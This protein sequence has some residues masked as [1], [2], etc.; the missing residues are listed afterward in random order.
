MARD[1]QVALDVGGFE[2]YEL[3]R[4]RFGQPPLD[5]PKDHILGRARA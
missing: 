1:T 4:Y 5:P 3:E 2:I